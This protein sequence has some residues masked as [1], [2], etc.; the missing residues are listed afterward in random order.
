MGVALLEKKQALENAAAPAGRR[1]QA[2][3][4]KFHGAMEDAGFGLA[5]A[6][7]QKGLAIYDRGLDSDGNPNGKSCYSVFVWVRRN[8]LEIRHQ[9]P[10]SSG[11]AFGLSP[12]AISNL[13][14]ETLFTSNS[15]GK[16]IAEIKG[17][18][19]K[20]PESTYFLALHDHLRY[21]NGSDLVALSM[22]DGMSD[23]T[24]M[25]LHKKGENIDF[26]FGTTCHNHF[27]FGQMKLVSELESAVGIT[28]GASVELTMPFSE[29]ST[30]GPHHL[31][32]FSNIYIA[33]EYQK[34]LLSRR[35]YKYP[36]YAPDT[37]PERLKNENQQLRKAGV[38][39]VGIAH[40]VAGVRTIA[41]VSPVGLIDVVGDGTS[42]LDYAFRYAKEYAD[43]VACFNPFSGTKPRDFV[44]PSE[45]GRM[46]ELVKKWKVGSDLSANAVNLAFAYE[47]RE[48]C[49]TAIHAD[50]DIHL[51]H[52][53]R[54][55]HTIHG[56]G[57]T[58]TILDASGWQARQGLFRKPTTQE[59]VS[60]LR[61]PQE[62][63]AISAFVPYS[64]E[65]AD[66][67]KARRNETLLQ[68]IEDAV[69]DACFHLT[70]TVPDIITDIRTRIHGVF[71]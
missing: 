65:T 60:I 31:L 70:H 12:R 21:V 3:F 57:K 36:A 8:A 59:I 58:R 64:A 66:L 15:I 53:F 14:I 49:R 38:L 48:R 37:K 44:N 62:R 4:Y 54:F 28:K 2:G 1:V 41:G 51:F 42:T 50:N 34:R 7:F 47:M 26:D 71:H 18:S 24:T 10:D 16:A 19:R 25:V 39:A 45:G 23:A 5:R 22:D 55:K 68:N 52:R 29:N 27:P 17:F 61:S 11:E 6:A 30:N 35:A 9:N 40:P 69:T 67:V 56:Y 63:A 43:S 46:L 20:K 33:R 32:W 13:R